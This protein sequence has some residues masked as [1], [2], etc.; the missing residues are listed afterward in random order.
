MPEKRPP[1]VPV[2]QCALCSESFPRD[3]VVSLRGTWICAACKP[4]FVQMLREGVSLADVTVARRKRTLIMGKNAP[5]PDRC[6]KCNAPAGNKRLK[7]RLYWHSPLLYLLILL[8]LLI[9]VLVAVIVRKRATIEIGLCEKHQSRRKA[10]VLTAWLAVLA[11]VGMFI[12]GIAVE[13]TGLLV[14]ALLLFLGG[15]VFGMATA[16]VVRPSRIDN[17]YVWLKGACREYLDALP[18]W[19]GAR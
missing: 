14:A 9:F 15:L 19:S 6:V 7:R 16:P 13:V 1:E 12:A 8:N 3:E 5:L 18:E 2:E 4:S 17:E 11:A 10:C